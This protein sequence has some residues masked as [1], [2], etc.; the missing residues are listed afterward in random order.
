M[1]V[2]PRVVRWADD[3]YKR[4]RIDPEWL[5]DC[6]A[7]LTTEVGHNPDTDFQGLVDAVKNQLLESNFTDSMLPGTGLPTHVAVPTTSM[8][9][10]GMQVLVEVASITEIANSAFNLDQTRQAREERLNDGDVEDEEGEGDIDIAGEGPIPK[11]PR[12]ML[13][14]HLTDGWTMLPAIEYR[15]LPQLSLENTPLGF[16]MLLKDVRINRGIAFLEPK[17]VVLVGC[18]TDDRDEN[19]LTDFA[20]GLRT[21]MRLPDL[22]PTDAHQNHA[23]PAPAVRNPTQLQAPAPRP[24][25]PAPAVRSPLRD[26]SP[27]PCPPAMYNNDDEDL[28]TRRRRIPIRNPEPDPPA[29]ERTM[30]PLPSSNRTIT[31]SYFANSSSSSVTTS[32]SGSKSRSQTAVGSAPG[33]SFLPMTLSPTIGQRAPR[34]LHFG[35]PPPSPGPEDEHF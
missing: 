24:P 16:K 18:K 31:S 17:C 8:T 33:P 19:R 26:I 1:A 23:A 34:N 6:Y 2:P 10:T 25:P 12:G 3:N 35:S 15:P 20:R 27:P 13:K 14:F 21:R 30:R 7:Y 11:Y 5:N 28:E 9:L 32:G 4:P 29:S 22:P